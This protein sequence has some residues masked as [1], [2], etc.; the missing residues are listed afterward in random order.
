MARQPQQQK[1]P[2]TLSRTSSSSH[3]DER[4]KKL[5][6][7]VERHQ[8]VSLESTEH[9]F[10]M[11]PN[12]NAQRSIQ[13]PSSSKTAH[14]PLSGRAEKI[15]TEETV[16]RKDASFKIC[17]ESEPVSSDAD[18]YGANDDDGHQGVDIHNQCRSVTSEKVSLRRLSVKDREEGSF[19]DRALS[20]R[21][22]IQSVR[23][24]GQEE[25]QFS[26]GSL[27]K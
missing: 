2:L 9:L 14:R 22:S 24:D 15:S 5:T 27:E 13:A 16:A 25:E 17:V 10:F 12:L 3:F 26:R 21:D 8:T 18:F 23:R 4:F 19:R 20:L 6:R 1:Q 7:L 11:N